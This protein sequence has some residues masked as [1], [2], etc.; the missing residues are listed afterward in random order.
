[1]SIRKNVELLA[2]AGGMS[3]LK[4]ALRFGADAVYL[5]M[6]RFG[7]RAGAKNFSEDEL[8]L[9]ASLT[10]KA[11]K[12][13]YVTLNIYPTEDQLPSLV[14]AAKSAREIGADAA[15]V[16]D[17]GAI[18]EIK[19]SVPDLEIHISTQANVTNS[20]AAALYARLGA[21]RI[22]LARELSYDKIRALRENLAG[23]VELEAFVHGASC[24]AY[25]GRCILSAALRGEYRS[26][27][28]GACAQPC[29][30]LYSVLKEKD[31]AEFDI[32]EDENGSYLMSANDL[33]LIGN[34]P[35]LYNCGIDSFKIEGR[36][37]SE[38]Y[39]ACAVRC[40]REAMQDY[41]KNDGSYQGKQEYYRRELEKIS[42]RHYDTGF[43]MK[44]VPAGGAGAYEQSMEYVGYVE[45][46]DYNAAFGA[47][48]ALV[49]VKGKLTLGDRLEAVTPDGVYPFT[50]SRMRREIDGKTI[51][52]CGQNGVRLRLDDIP[53]RLSSGDMLRGPNRNHL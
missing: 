38:Y 12:R 24:M 6:P 40:Y 19:N 9:A 5:G 44:N 13:L 36:M 11:G 15:I 50:L 31:G 22:V 43:F 52:S 41:V 4:A 23:S 7:M 33:C 45:D 35:E 39:T 47:S 3:Q 14:S 25:S 18:I 34:L 10:H 32:S 27:N 20:R 17:I 29:R 53:A 28:Q 51:D 42:H 49:T 26:A 48:S 1:M 30:R 37:K 2:P 46:A 16:A 8:A 21:K